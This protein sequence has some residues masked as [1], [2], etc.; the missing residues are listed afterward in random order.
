MSTHVSGTIWRSGNSSKGYIEI[1]EVLQEGE[2]RLVDYQKTYL[3]GPG[4]RDFVVI[5]D[6]PPSSF[7]E[8]APGAILEGLE[9]TAKYLHDGQSLTIN[10]RTGKGFLNVTRQSP[11]KESL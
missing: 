1:A 7:V 5:G 2:K 11:Q 10:A 6:F 8:A 3:L 9:K 4:E